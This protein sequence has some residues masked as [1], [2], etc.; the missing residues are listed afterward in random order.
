MQLL[1]VVPTWLIKE[2]DCPPRFP[3]S[4]GGRCSDPRPQ[5][6]QARAPGSSRMA[7]AY[8]PNVA[9]TGAGTPL[10]PLPVSSFPVCVPHEATRA[11]HGLA[12]RGPCKHVE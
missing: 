4:R 9:M 3:D 10:R 5:P 2:P 6:G 1:P 7:R 11:G 12:H 8:K